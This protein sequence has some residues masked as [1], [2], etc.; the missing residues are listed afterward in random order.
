MPENNAHEPDPFDVRSRLRGLI[1][2]TC[3]QVYEGYPSNFT[4]DFGDKHVLAVDSLWRILGDGRVLRTSLDHGQQ[5][6]LPRSVDAFSEA[7]S[8]LKDREVTDVQVRAVSADLTLQFDGDYSLEVIPDSSG[9]ESWRFDAPGISIV[10][11]G[12]GN[13]CDMS[14]KT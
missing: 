10:A 9:Y 6:G 7:A 12:G 13:I 14:P 3:M 4:F 2:R 8:L 11:Q 5:F 1:G